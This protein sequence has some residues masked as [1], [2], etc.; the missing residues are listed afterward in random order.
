MTQDT[1][2]NE[3]LEVELKLHLP[4]GGRIRVEQLPSFCEVEPEHRH[5]VTTYYDTPGLDLRRQGAALRVRRR[6]D[7]RVQTLKTEDKRR[8]VAASRGEWEW[9]ISTDQ[10]DLALL[11]D[12]PLRD[13]VQ[14]L[15][16]QLQPVFT[17]DIHRIARTLRPDDG[18][19]V[20]AALDEGIVIAGNRSERVSELELEL[21]DGARLGALYR[22]ALELHSAVALTITGESKAERGY[23]LRTGQPAPSHKAPKLDLPDDI[24]ANEGFG[25]MVGATL[26]HLLANTAA[27]EAGDPEGVHQIRVALRRLRSVLMLFKRDLEP[28][29]ATLFGEE[30][31]RLGQTFGEARD[32][33]VFTLDT[34]TTAV[35]DHPGADWLGFLRNA[36]E[37]KRAEAN[38]RA[39]AALHGPEFTRIVLSMAA[40]VED[41]AEQPALLGDPAMHAR[42]K[43]IAP[44]L[45]DRVHRKVLKRGRDISELADDELHALRKA[46]K[47][48]RYDS[49]Y[50]G[51]LFRQ[52]EVKAY[53]KCCEDLQELLGTLNDTT[54]TIALAEELVRGGHPELAPAIAALAQWC[55]RRRE[56]SLLKLGTAWAE[57]KSTAPFWK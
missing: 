8:R 43:D 28:H 20:E 35:S 7:S 24:R 56:R 13:F 22:F 50:L 39:I 32:W 46:L 3:P 53:R 55:G 51:G 10:P 42:L 29:T 18:L 9:E 14:K 47:K 36:A 11:A 52:K 40:W 23:R 49:E 2:R 27:T 17:T 16:G 5:E 21:K 30:L 1:E 25:S 45:L 54:T 37:S 6:D 19:V 38:K 57:F 4:P 34:L 44:S 31:K 26:S 12:T 15:G 33:D 41:G 48:L